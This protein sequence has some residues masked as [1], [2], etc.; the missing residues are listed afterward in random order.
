MIDVAALVIAC[1]T[2]ASAPAGT[3]E[4][5]QR[6]YRIGPDPV[7]VALADLDENGTLDILVANRGQLRDPRDEHPADETVSFLLGREDGSFDSQPPLPCGF[8][9]YQV[10]VANI[11]ALRAPDI[12]IANFF[13]VRNRD[14]TL[15][16]NLDA[17]VFEPRHFTVPDDSVRYS[18]ARDSEG[19]PLFSTPGLTSLAVADLNG[20]GY[21]DAISTGWGSDVL[22]EFPGNPEKYFADPILTPL[23]GGPRDVAIDD[24][25][26][27]GTL[28]LAVT[29]YD[30]DEIA[31]LK[32]VAK[33]A[34]E[35]VDKFSSRG[36]MP[37]KIKI[38]D[39]NGDKRSDLI[40]T[41]EQTSDSVIIF[42]GE[43]KFAFPVSQEISLGENRFHREVGVED[44]IVRDLNSDDRP[45]LALACADAGAVYVL[46]NVSDG[47]S[48]PLRFEI[49]KY[50][51]DGGAP[52]ALAAGD[53][54][55]DGK[56]DI[57]VA[58]W[59]VDSVGFLFSRP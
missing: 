17:G 22:V 52:H 47:K 12:L 11:D 23:E 42:F 57:A 20:D 53:I 4:V 33:G 49:E 15:L 55:R 45:D 6:R 38:A 1:A 26:G 54:T 56:P 28:D 44:V 10:V 48:A 58:L 25:D 35:L 37:Q 46:R 40:V 39:I 59:G 27:D 14:L 9:P 50:A 13:E 7:S 8:G 41:H 36:K 34:F 24:L 2:A 3:F 16:R 19:Q 18:Q 5:Q 32:G 30:T 21:R 51:F 43:G 31:I 29:L